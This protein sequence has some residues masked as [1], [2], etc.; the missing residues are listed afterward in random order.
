MRRSLFVSVVLILALVVGLC[1]CYVKFPTFGGRIRLRE[2]VLEK[3]RGTKDKILLI[4]LSGII[5]SS[6]S[7]GAFSSRDNMV[8]VLGMQLD[9]ARMDKHIKGL[10]LT[11]N[12]PGGAVTASEII[13]HKIMKFKREKGVPVVILMGDVAASGGYYISM[14]GDKIIAHPTTITG[15]IG[16]ISMFFNLHGLFNKIG[17]DVVTLKTGAMKDVGSF[18]RPMKPEEKAY[19]MTILKQMYGV[20]LDRVLAS[21]TQ[22]TRED[23][24]KL[25][26]GRV[27]T[28]KQALEAKLIDKIGYFEDA[29]SAVKEEGNFAA[30][31]IVA[32]DWPWNHK[33]DVYSASAPG[34]PIDIN[35]LKLDFNTLDSIGRPG[36]YYIWAE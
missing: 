7:R 9:K 2:Q 15:S 11:V 29:V 28:A 20:F 19:I 8:E 14:A 17:V 30:A 3:A 35:L 16:V 18:A 24:L 26:D 4:P 31:S 23:L 10:I 32:Y 1:G 25:A 36:F 12:S 5:S 27:F 21:R 33:Y 6:S 34:R 13:Y 22:L